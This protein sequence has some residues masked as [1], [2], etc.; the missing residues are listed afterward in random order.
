MVCVSLQVLLGCF[1]YLIAS[2]YY[3]YCFSYFGRELKCPSACS[4][5]TY[6]LLLLQPPTGINTFISFHIQSNT[7]LSAGTSSFDVEFSERDDN[8]L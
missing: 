5:E 2:V 8:E 7:G 6:Y 3:L 4:A 1:Y